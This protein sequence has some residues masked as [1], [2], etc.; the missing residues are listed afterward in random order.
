MNAISTAV[1]ALNA[2]QKKL[3]VIAD[4]VA[5]VN[6]DG[7]KKSRV[8]MEQGRQGGVQARIQKIETPGIPRK[9]IHGGSAG[10]AETS[11][12]DLIEELTQMIPAEKSYGANLKAL[13][14][15]NNMLGHLLDIFS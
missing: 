13:R 1:S 4:N 8:T 3:G 10:D 9:T 7:F 12:V 15:S 2:F 5:N 11:N 14:T 6:T